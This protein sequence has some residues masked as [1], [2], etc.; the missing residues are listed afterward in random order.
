MPQDVRTWYFIGSDVPAV[1]GMRM[2]KQGDTSITTAGKTAHP[3][4]PPLLPPPQES[5]FAGSLVCL[6]ALEMHLVDIS[7]SSSTR[8]MWP[9]SAA[10]GAGI[11]TVC[12]RNSKVRSGGT[13]W[14][15]GGSARMVQVPKYTT[16]C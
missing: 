10:F 9:I 16:G 6:R 13:G 11:L 14:V 2:S 4:P 12:F 5:S 3:P 1:M 8:S 7:R 15:A